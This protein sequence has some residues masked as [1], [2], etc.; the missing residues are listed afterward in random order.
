MT[1]ATSNIAKVINGKNTINRT[2]PA[3]PISRVASKHSRISAATK[4]AT[5]VSIKRTFWGFVKSPNLIK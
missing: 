3:A 4:S 5:A 1:A 2:I